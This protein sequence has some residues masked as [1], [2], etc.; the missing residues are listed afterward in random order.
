MVSYTDETSW[1][2]YFVSK[3]H[4]NNWGDSLVLIQDY[5]D[6]FADFVAMRNV[7]LLYIV[8]W[9]ILIAVAIVY[10]SKSLYQP[11]DN[12]V[13]FTSDLSGNEPAE[14]ETNEFGQLMEWYKDTY[15]KLHGKN[16]ASQYFMKRYQ[17]EKLLTD[18][19]PAVWQNFCAYLP[20]HWIIKSENMPVRIMKIRMQLDKKTA[21]NMS[22]EN[23][24]M[25]LFVIEN[26]MTEL[27]EKEYPVEIFQVG[28]D[29]LCGIVQ[30][31]EGVQ[32]LILENV[33]RETQEYVQTFAKLHFCAAYSEANTGHE[34]FVK[35]YKQ[36]GILLEYEYI[37]GENAIINLSLCE[38]NLKNIG[39]D[40]PEQEER[41]MISALK[42]LDA[43]KTE[44]YLDNIFAYIETMRIDNVQLA[45][46]TLA[47]KLNAVLKEQ[48]QSRGT[49][50]KAELGQIYHD[51]VESAN[52][53]E[54]KE[55]FK[56][57]IEDSLDILTQKKDKN[58]IF[59]EEVKKYVEENYP[60]PNLSSQTVGDYMGLSGKYVMK[61]FQ[62]YTGTSLNDYIYLKRM[63][64]AAELLTSS[65]ESISKIAEQIGIVNEN[66]FYKLFKKAYGCTPREYSNNKRNNL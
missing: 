20:D 24:N 53:D 55:Y 15:S 22:E 39:T 7:F 48:H 16:K 2:K 44:K 65:N 30:A 54:A 32:D 64:K 19:S 62:D 46:M 27:M 37:F 43:D 28:E 17:Y 66:Y 61:K 57:Y 40:F 6:V 63:N 26:I 34:A 10:V 4:L 49:L 23:R 3:L 52:L 42:S 47:N 21:E 36:A 59:V 45:I 35:M 33:I 38:A 25:Y 31:S 29:A 18:D 5:D 41:K 1:K 58:Q 14:S 12:L 11:I 9:T 13:K 8:I 50:E 51:I 60:D 56:A